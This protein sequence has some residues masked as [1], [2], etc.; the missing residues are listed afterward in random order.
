MWTA[1]CRAS[2]T[3]WIAC[4][5]L[6]MACACGEDGEQPQANPT[7]DVEDDPGA[8]E[9]PVGEAPGEELP[10]LE[11]MEEPDEREQLEAECFAGSTA[12]CDAL[13]H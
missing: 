11:E 6:W 1:L 8:S 13:G 12:A 2:V 5:L 10:E 3:V 7:A 9:Q 4:G